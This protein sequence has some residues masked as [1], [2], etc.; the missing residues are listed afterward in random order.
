MLLGL[1]LHRNL[2]AHIIIPGISS[3]GGVQSLWVGNAL[4]PTAVKK[5]SLTILHTTFHLLCICV[6]CNEAFLITHRFLFAPEWEGQA[7]DCSSL[8]RVSGSAQVAKRSDQS[9]STCE[10][11]EGHK[12]MTIPKPSTIHPQPACSPGQLVMQ[13]WKAINF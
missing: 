2:S 11:G 8:I 12:Y 4:L 9:R 3:A 10:G 13:P 5:S 6:H 7:L 1:E